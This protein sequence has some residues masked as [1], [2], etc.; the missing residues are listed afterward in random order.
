MKTKGAFFLASILLTSGFS[1]AVTVLPQNALAAALYVGGTGPGNHTLIQDAIDAASPLDS[2]Y[3]YSGTYYEHL[4]IPKRLSLIGEDETTTIIDGGGTG[5]VV[6]ISGDGV[7]LTG[8]TVR[9]SGTGGGD[10]GI[11]LS[12]TQDCF[13]DGNIVIHSELSNCA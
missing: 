4:T 5:R 10:R 6:R 7:V 9:N 12:M 1:L 3:V 13:I 2:I 8:F 11:S